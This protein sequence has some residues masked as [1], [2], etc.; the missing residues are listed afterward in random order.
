MRS[1][2]GVTLIE[3]MVALALAAIVLTIGIPSFRSIIE[4]NQLTTRTNEI[5]TLLNLARSDAVRRGAP[6]SICPVTSWANGMLIRPGEACTGTGLPDAV[7]EVEFAQG[8]VDQTVA[9]ANLTRVTFSGLGQLVTA[10][11]ANPL[12]F[13]LDIANRCSSTIEVNAIGWV[14]SSIEQRC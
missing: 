14:S 2:R 12:R 6:V 10:P 3:L 4:N 1:A 9:P 8:R 7:R 5:V 13:S 11:T